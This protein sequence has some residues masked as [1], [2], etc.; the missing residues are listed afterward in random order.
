[1]N[2]FLSFFLQ[3][4]VFSVSSCQEGEISLAHALIYVVRSTLLFMLFVMDGVSM[5]SRK[6]WTVVNLVGKKLFAIE[7]FHRTN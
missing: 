5:I 2:Y 7:V 3:F 1:M 4:I 6:K